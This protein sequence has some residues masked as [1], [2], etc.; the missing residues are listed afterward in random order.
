MRKER[1]KR[2]TLVPATVTTDKM[3]WHMHVAHEMDKVSQRK[4]AF[5]STH[6]PTSAQVPSN[7]INIAPRLT[8][9]PR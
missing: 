1:T 6:S 7:K 8:H 2:H 3:E 5:L 4:V 9:P